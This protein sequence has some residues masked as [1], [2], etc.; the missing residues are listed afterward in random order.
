VIELS[1]IYPTRQS[2]IQKPQGQSDF[3]QVIMSPLCHHW[4]ARKELYGWV[5]YPTGLALIVYHARVSRSNPH[6][7]RP[8]LCVFPLIL[9]ADSV[10]EPD[11]QVFVITLAH[12]QGPN[13]TI[14]EAVRPQES[15]S[16]C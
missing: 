9:G 2:A 4:D 3:G 1:S 8:A 13:A 5:S 14:C 15:H 11:T 6:I 7:R 12:D 10:L 16:I